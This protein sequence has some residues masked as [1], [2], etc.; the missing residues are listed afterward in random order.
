MV[1]AANVHHATT[2]ALLLRSTARRRVGSR[3]SDHGLCAPRHPA[4]CP[5]PVVRVHRGQPHAADDEGYESG[6]AGWGA[7]VVPVPL[8]L[9]AELDLVPSQGGVALFVRPGGTADQLGV[10]PGDVIL[11][12]NGTAVTNRR[13]I[14]SVVR[15]ASPGEAVEVTAITAGGARET[16]TGTFQERQ[17][18]PSGPPPWFGN[19]TQPP[20]ADLGPMRLEDQRA[21]L[22]ADKQAL[23][24]IAAD[25]VRA[26]AELTQPPQRPAW[27]FTMH[28]EVGDQP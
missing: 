8:E 14:R 5:R 17:P 13:D 24:R 11:D 1:A 27:R 26:T 12:I 15:A 6:R 9:Q 16:L 28:I 7:L 4:L 25:L 3:N 18:R 19:G 21:Q 10:A 2:P 23:E 20:W 22:V